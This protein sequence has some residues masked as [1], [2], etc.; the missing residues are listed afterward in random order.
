MTW[1]ELLIVSH[2]RLLPRW[3]F[4]DV[5]GIILDWFA[6]PQETEGGI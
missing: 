6:L 2:E 5:R 4:Y 3:Q 1:Q